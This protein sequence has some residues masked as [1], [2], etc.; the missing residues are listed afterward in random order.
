MDVQGAQKTRPV[1]H[2]WHVPGTAVV[3]PRCT[4]LKH[5]Q[6]F[7]LFKGC[8]FTIDQCLSAPFFCTALACP[9]GLQPDQ[10]FPAGHDDTSPGDFPAGR[11]DPSLGDFYVYQRQAP[12]PPYLPPICH[13]RNTLL[14]AVLYLQMKQCLIA[15]SG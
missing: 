9:R 11:G 3:P 2:V 5:R 13:K 14:L 1:A 12:G 7:S 6:S 8:N 10:L 4:D 15:Q